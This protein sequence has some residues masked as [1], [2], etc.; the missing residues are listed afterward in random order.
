[1]TLPYQL[2]NYRVEKR[3]PNEKS[4]DKCGAATTLPEIPFR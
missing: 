4:R 3:V 1:M 2:E